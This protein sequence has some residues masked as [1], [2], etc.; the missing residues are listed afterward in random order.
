MKKF[1]LAVGLLSLAGTAFAEGKPCEELKAEIAA[2]L[3]AK[4][5]SNYSLEIVDKGA[6]AGGKVVGKCEKGS[7]E[8][9]YKQ[10]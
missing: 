1:I 2:K 3:D 8:I 6:A 4:G 5:I 10:G 7:K 9:V